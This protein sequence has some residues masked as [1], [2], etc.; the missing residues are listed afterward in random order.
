MLGCK[1]NFYAVSKM[2]KL[3]V[4]NQ[5]SNNYFDYGVQCDLNTSEV[6]N[7][8]QH[9]CTQRT[10]SFQQEISMPF[11]APTTT[12]HSSSPS[13]NILLWTLSPFSCHTVDSFWAGRLGILTVSLLTYILKHAKWATSPCQQLC[14]SVWIHTQTIL[15]DVLP[16]VQNALMEHQRPTKHQTIRFCIYIPLQPDVV[17][18]GHSLPTKCR[19]V[20]ER[21]QEASFLSATNL[22]C[23]RLKG[24]CFCAGHSE[25]SQNLWAGVCVCVQSSFSRTEGT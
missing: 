21:T 25:N 8:V 16:K 18:S 1:W 11:S 4:F 15:Y 2:F 13:A 3:W 24:E 12:F 17:E 9:C 20:H 6:Y 19:V 22:W 23:Y 5:T 14:N 10:Y 7:T